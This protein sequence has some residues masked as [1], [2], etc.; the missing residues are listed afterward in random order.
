MEPDLSRF[1]E[2]QR[3]DYPTALKEIRNGKKESHWMW[4]IFPQLRGLGES[5]TSQRY[6][7]RDLEEARAFLADPYLGGNL[8]EISEALLS[9]E[10]DDPRAVFGRPDDMKLRSSMTLFALVSEEGSV[11]HRV[12]D[13]YCGGRLD[14]RT[15]G[16][17][18]IR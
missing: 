16:L 6:A 4:Y 14:A 10:T 11:F 17:L 8:R 5:Q 7:V 9:L 12:L 2:A 15:L 18:G 1:V 3:R 13:K